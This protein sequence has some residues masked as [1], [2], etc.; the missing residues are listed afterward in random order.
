MDT[1]SID[2]SVQMTTFGG[3]ALRQSREKGVVSDGG[4]ACEGSWAGQVSAERVTDF[5]NGAMRRYLFWTHFVMGLAAGLF[6]LIMSAT[7]VLL[8]FESQMLAWARNAA[9]E[10]PEDARP[11][12]IQALAG[13][14]REAGAGSG[15]Q[16]IVPQ[17]RSD[18]VEL[19]LDRRDRRF[20][21][22]F[23]GEPIGEIW[24]EGVFRRI[25][26]IHRWLAFQGG[27]Q[28]V[29]AALN[30][31]ANLLFAG[32]LITGAILWLEVPAR[33]G[34]EDPSLPRAGRPTPRHATQLAPCLRA[35]S[36]A[37]KA[38][39]LRRVDLLFRQPELDALF[40]DTPRRCQRRQGTAPPA[41]PGR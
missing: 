12:S 28:E 30:A 8:T 23:A 17:D 33:P 36:R 25:T 3:K 7:G 26:A 22:P 15:S 34:T 40:D 35:W 39:V 18:A 24:L 20:L 10:V 16:L 5:W 29:G 27:R 21:D 14:A 41:R 9:I 11:L 31:A 1:R 6:V 19:R 38:I 2:T 37:A 4:A 13:I 32:L